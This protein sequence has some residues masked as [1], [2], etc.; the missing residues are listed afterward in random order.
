[1]KDLHTTIKQMAEYTILVDRVR[2]EQELQSK[3]DKLIDRLIDESELITA[4]QRRQE[5]LARL[6][7]R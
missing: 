3:T 6:A 1:M 5:E 4:D 2:Y 7:R